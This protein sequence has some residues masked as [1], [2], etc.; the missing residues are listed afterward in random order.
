MELLFGLVQGVLGFGFSLIMIIFKLILA[1]IAGTVAT[2]KHRNGLIWGVLTFIFPW[3]ILILP[4]IPKKYPKF[5]GN[6]AQHD[7][8]KGRNPVIASIMALSAMVAK[9]GGNITKEEIAVV[10]EFVTRYFGVAREELNQYGDAFDYG[11]NHPEEYQEFTTI[12]TNF[13]AGRDMRIAISYLL[14]SIAMQNGTISD[15]EDTLIRTILAQLGI[16]TYEYA[17]IKNSFNQQYQYYGYEQSGSYNSQGG[18]GGQG[19]GDNSGALIKKYSEVL[20]VS[21]DATMAEIK[22]AYRRLVKEYHPDKLASESMPQDYV[23]FANQKIREINE[24][25][26]YLKSVKEA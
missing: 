24:A 15:A 3:A 4:F 2:Y 20:G 19:F 13:Y 21:E 1:F 10:K 5:T 26:E 23:E 11:K 12:I 25:Y 8:F 7:A 14:V 9:A 22:K 18:F 17:S 16:S 6:L